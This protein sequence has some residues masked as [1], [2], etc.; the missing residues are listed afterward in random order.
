MNTPAASHLSVELSGPNTLGERRPLLSSEL[1]RGVMG[2]L[3]IAHVDGAAV[4]TFHHLHARSLAAE[5]GLEPLI[6]FHLGLPCPFSFVRLANK[7]RRVIEQIKRIV[8]VQLSTSSG[9][10]M[11]F[12]VPVHLQ[13]TLHLGSHSGE[14]VERS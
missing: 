2:P 4:R 13:Q 6:L 1:S 7:E 10:T 11:D 12:F 9:T 8:K 3:A 14:I 5:A